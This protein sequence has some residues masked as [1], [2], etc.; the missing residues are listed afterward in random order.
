MPVALERKIKQAGKILRAAPNDR[1]KILSDI[2]EVIASKHPNARTFSGLIDSD[3]EVRGK[4]LHSANETLSSNGK[5]F[6]SVTSMTQV[7]GLYP[8][9][10][11]L[12]AT[13]VYDTFSQTPHEKSILNHCHNVAIAASQLA[14]WIY[15]ITPF[16]AYNLGMMHNIGAIY[17]LRSLEGYIDLY[18]SYLYFPLENH[19]QE[20]ELYQTDHACL[21]AVMA[22]K[23]GLNKHHTR[24]IL[25]H[26]NAQ[27]K[28]QLEAC[29]AS[30]K[31]TALLMLAN[32]VTNVFYNEDALTP[33]QLRCRDIA[34]SVLSDLPKNAV[35]AAQAALNE[36]GKIINF[37]SD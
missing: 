13:L 28:T 12:C 18:T 2:H 1:P 17:M 35:Q 9:Y 25:F 20:I 11:L 29:P 22:K 5:P 26:H 23:W 21:G 19:E 7:Y 8:T 34:K 3:P 24:A 37:G 32:Y 30:L 16:E 14:Y 31:F 27:F 4:L 33:D 15:E 10:S 36:R 6:D